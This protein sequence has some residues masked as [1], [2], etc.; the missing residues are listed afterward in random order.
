MYYAYNML[1][2]TNS[3]DK[4]MIYQLPFIIVKIQ[5]LQFSVFLKI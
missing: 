1:E 4:V 5:K 2:I 3:L